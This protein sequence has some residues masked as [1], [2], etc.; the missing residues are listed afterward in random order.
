MPRLPKLFSDTR[1][2]R[3]LRGD[4]LRSFLVRG[5]LGGAALKAVQA[6]LTFAVAVLL[7]RALGPED[8]G[9]Y[10]FALSLSF[11]LAVPSQMGLPTLM[12]REVARYHLKTEWGRLR[13]FLR[14][15]N[16][17]VL[18]F[19]ALLV[20]VAV[21]VAMAF[22]GQAEKSELATFGWALA[23]VPLAALGNLRGAALR[24]LRKVVLG[25][26]PEKILR[27]A[28][29]LLLAGAVA[30]FGTLSAPTAMAL[31]ALAA[32]LAFAMGIVL[33]LRALPTEVRTATPAY[34]SRHWLGSILPLSVISGMQVINHQTDVV[35]LGLLSTSEELGVYRVAYQGSALVAFTLTIAN[36]VI[37]PQI[38]RLY[39]SGETDKLQRMITWSARAIFGFSLPPAA[40][41]VFYGEP[42]LVLAFGERYSEGYMALA[43]L[44]IGQMATVA[45]GPAA[46]VLNMTGHERDTARAVALAAASNVILN[47]ILIPTFGIEGA[48]VA[49]GV[50]L[51]LAN[52]LLYRHARKRLGINSSIRPFQW[53]RLSSSG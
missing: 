14:W 19:S 7:A 11:L 28:L 50:S 3:V 20:L 32:A 2:Y 36:T 47:L 39:H 17:A 4:G 21:L 29:L 33:L 1:R 24:G 44:C 12:V 49:T 45:L 35:L 43:I 31:H 5:F 48:A 22:S 27:P 15:A 37:H 30:A 6:L 41:F 53:G 34:Q 13:G 16:V 38:T 10:T 23:L 42:V 46:S 51:S 26:L 52:T 40:I 8:Y 9:V 25:Q 18:A